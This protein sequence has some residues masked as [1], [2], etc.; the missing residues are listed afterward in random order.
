MS[1]RGVALIE[2]LLSVVLLGTIGTSLLMLLGQ[3]RASIHSTQATEQTIDS[4]SDALDRM[5]VEDHETLV[6]RVGWTTSG[7]FAL[8]VEQISSSLFEVEIA[9]RP[10]DPP[11]LSTTFYRIDSTDAR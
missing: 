5:V 11:L 4:A 7:D 6:R 2:T 1:R 9:R 8:H 10:G 3:T